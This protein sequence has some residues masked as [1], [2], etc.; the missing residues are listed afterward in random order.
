MTS[1]TE[2]CEKS[3]NCAKESQEAKVKLSFWIQILT[4][5]CTMSASLPFE[6]NPFLLKEFKIGLE[7]SEVT[8]VKE[9][10]D[11]ERVSVPQNDE[12]A[13][14]LKQLNGETSADLTALEKKWLD[15]KTNRQSLMK[16]ETQPR[17]ARPPPRR[18]KFR[19]EGE[20]VDANE[21]NTD[22]NK[23]PDEVFDR[24][25]SMLWLAPS[26]FGAQGCN[27][28]SG[29]KFDAPFPFLSGTFSCSVEGLNSDLMWD[30]FKT[31]CVNEASQNAHN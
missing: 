31:R 25:E 12:T 8:S 1:H 30:Y 14:I 11:V 26:Y 4:L 3:E 21:K 16:V 5:I 6:R 13:G 27:P 15:R 7:K 22:G 24:G 28:R 19:N 10:H 17:S 2:K 20:F 9:G 29:D 23:G 18:D